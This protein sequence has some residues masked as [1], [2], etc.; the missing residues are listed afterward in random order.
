MSLESGTV[1]SPQTAPESLDDLAREAQG[2][3]MLSENIR[4]L[5]E[6][7][8]KRETDH[9]QELHDQVERFAAE[10]EELERGF[11]LQLDDQ[12]RETQRQIEFLL[13]ENNDCKAQMVAEIVELQKIIEGDR[14]KIT[15]LEQEL[16]LCV[17][18][19]DEQVLAVHRHEDTA[20][21]M[22]LQ[23]DQL[24]AQHKRTEEEMEHAGEQ[25]LH[26]KMILKEYKTRFCL[27]DCSETAA[28]RQEIRDLESEQRQTS[29]QLK[30]HALEKSQEAEQRRQ[31]E[32][33]VRDLLQVQ[34][35]CQQ[36]EAKWNKAREEFDAKCA[37]LETEAK[38]LEERLD[39]ATAEVAT[40]KAAKESAT[41][42]L[43]QAT[44][45]LERHGSGLQ[46]KDLQIHRVNEALQRTK[47]DMMAKE[48]HFL[49]I[50]SDNAALRKDNRLLRDDNACLRQSLAEWKSRCEELE[51]MC[52]ERRGLVERYEK[53]LMSL[54]GSRSV[55]AAQ[56][57]FEQ[58]L[59]SNLR[60][61]SSLQH[62]LVK[63]A[64]AAQPA[65]QAS[66]V[67]QADMLDSAAGRPEE[68]PSPHR[69]REQ[70]LLTLLLQGQGFQMH[71]TQHPEQAL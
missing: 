33:Q 53:Q 44:E 34:I 16:A 11:L 25:A 56:T 39:A 49:G 3:V 14:L 40:C 58:L 59:H 46:E 23:L 9:R 20:K 66:P 18:M 13:E 30:Q 6:Q 51:A 71:Q 47:N 62:Q 42:K 4:T 5:K 29:L 69:L 7:Y 57:Q 35:A 60:V 70:S 55:E 38:E 48:E 61:A 64:S 32:E 21:Q 27:S 41:M 12:K 54:R 36:K 1:P 31:L 17:Q 22:Q 52:M 68:P 24:Q 2:L 50:D 45:Q 8:V 63:G 26:N 10:K 19:K 37:K 67:R 43:S 28:L 15:T 65:A